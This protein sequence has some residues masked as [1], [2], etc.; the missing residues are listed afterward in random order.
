MELIYDIR[1]STLD[2]RFG[3]PSVLSHC[4]EVPSD[5]DSDWKAE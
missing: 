1:L 2:W 3:E 4:K 5:S